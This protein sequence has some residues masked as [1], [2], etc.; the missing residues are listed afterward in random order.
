MT[1]VNAIVL[2]RVVAN[3]ATLEAGA[4]ALSNRQVGFATT[5]GIMLLRDDYGAFHEF[6][7]SVAIA[8]EIT[9]QIAATSHNALADR[10]VADCHPISAITGLTST[11]ASKIAKPAVAYAGD[12]I[13][14]QSGTYGSARLRAFHGC[15][16]SADA[17]GNSIWPDL[18]V[19]YVSATRTITVTGHAWIEGIRYNYSGV[20]VTHAN[21]LSQFFYY[22]SSSGIVTVSGTQFDIFT[23][24]PLLYVWHDPA[25]AVNCDW[26]EERHGADRDRAWHYTQHFA[27]DGGTRVDSISKPIITGLTNG[28]ESPNSPT[29]A[30]NRPAISLHDIFDEDI[31]F[32]INAIAD[33]GPYTVLYYNGTKPIHSVGLSN[34]FT[35]GTSYVQYNNPASGMVESTNNRFIVMF[36]FSKPSRRGAGYDCV[37]IPA[38][39]DFGSYSEAVAYSVSQMNLSWIPAMEFV[40]F[41]KSIYKLS[42]G[43]STAGK[44]GHCITIPI[45]ATRGQASET[46]AGIGGSGT[47]GYV[48]LWTGT[49]SLGNSRI[50]DDGTNVTT[51]DLTISGLT[52]SRALYADA[53]KKLQ[54][55]TTTNTELGYVSGVTS[56]IQTQLN[57]KAPTSHAATATTY[58]VGSATNYGHVKLYTS[59]GTSTD[60]AMDRNSVT[61]A[62]GGKVSFSTAGT[63]NYIP[64]CTG[65]NTLGNSRIT[66]DGSKV[67]IAGEVVFHALPVGQ[68]SLADA[69]NVYMGGYSTNGWAIWAGNVAPSATNY[70][71]YATGNGTYATIQG[72]VQSALGVNNLDKVRA[73]AADVVIKPTEVGVEQFIFQ[74]YTGSSLAAIY[75]GGVVTPSN[76]N[77]ALLTSATS[78]QLNA[79]TA[80]YLNI[81]DVPK[82]SVSSSLVSTSVPLEVG[83]SIT[84][85]ANNATDAKK[86][87]LRPYSTGASA[88]CIYNGGVPAGLDNYALFTTA[89]TTETNATTSVS[90]NI[91]NNYR[92]FIDSTSIRA[93]GSS[94]SVWDTFASTH[95]KAGISNSADG[96]TK[97]GI[98]AGSGTGVSDCQFYRDAANIWLTPDS[99]KCPD[100]I[101]N[102][103]N[104]TATAYNLTADGANI[105][106]VGGEFFHQYVILSTASKSISI[107]HTSMTVGQVAFGSFKIQGTYSNKGLTIYYT[108]IDGST[109]FVSV[110]G[111]TND[112]KSVD[113][114]FIR[115]GDGFRVIGNYYA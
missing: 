39:S 98:F 96:S 90:L 77:Y 26:M 102:N 56:A 70:M 38:Q 44:A 31:R 51:P 7:G 15:P 82:V 45:S 64:V 97:G 62:L 4:L 93:I 109:K 40:P 27:A 94:V 58:G 69:N 104:N 84:S 24:A 74:K 25:D 66:D 60:G 10:D 23:Q 53:N 100:F 112:T 2:R 30:G 68:V 80:V 99:I 86:L 103:T 43:Y 83:G 72:T 50:A 85:D 113:H 79:T 81:A 59:T 78:T 92:L 13:T 67:A 87:V 57:G 76:T 32:R 65:T 17:N 46:S 114:M 20:S 18:T 34:I 33:N 88:A 47:V 37:F 61:S 8:S 75:N 19:D 41:A 107:N 108:G 42:A 55:S 105:T 89:T 71:F 5:D 28:G 63:T 95:A 16:M 35:I 36:S 3:R 54:S 101:F 106:P 73:S 52:A 115:S 110:N 21:T 49:S 91:S 14:Y 11:L 111:V 9:A 48:P 22:I 1:T 12:S 6:W 29:D